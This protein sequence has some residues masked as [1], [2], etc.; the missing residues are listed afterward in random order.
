MEILITG[1]SGQDGIFLTKL[2][3]E[4]YKNF[5][6]IGISRNFSKTQLEHKAKSNF[7]NFKILNIDLLNKQEVHN[8][9]TKVKPSIVFNLSGPSSVYES[10]RNHKL[11][12]EIKIIFNNLTDSLV[13]NR[14]FCNF[15]QASS[16]EMYGLN[17]KEEQYTEKS[18]FIPNSPYANAKLINHNKVKELHKIYD[19]KIFSGILFNHESEFRQPDYL[20]MK[21]IRGAIEIKNREKNYLQ[22]GSLELKRDWSY[23]EEIVEGIFEMTF[24]G[25]S[26]DYVLGSGRATSIKEVVEIIFSYFELDYK[27]FIKIDNNILRENDPDIVVADPSKIKND[28]G[29]STRKDIDEFLHI[30]IKKYLKGKI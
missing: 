18:S 24:H 20:I 28:L 27:Q 8:F 21:I 22:L 17:N 23:A 14:N 9:L 13:E 11:E 5:E 16:S 1:I 10:L 12:N 29:W 2:L 15:F 7:H 19:W 25:K 30:I 6:I 4:K 26:P 3:N